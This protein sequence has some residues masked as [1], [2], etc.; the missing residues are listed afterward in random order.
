MAWSDIKE[1]SLT[2]R[3]IQSKTG[4][5]VII[6]LHST[7]LKI[8]EEQRKKLLHYTVQPE[9]VFDLPTANG[10]NKML[11]L[12][13][14]EAGINKKYTWSCARLSFSV[15]LQ[16]ENVDTATVAYLLG[17]TTTKQV[18]RVYK[19]HRPK[20][21]RATIS[22]LPDKNQRQESRS[23]SSVN[24]NTPIN[25]NWELLYGRRQ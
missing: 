25:S 17:H 22:K 9:L 15:L 1:N 7:A 20:D 3:M 5:P 4:Q 16:D 24:L 21:Q 10:A 14:K 23:V 2:T 11:G 18:E 8:I 6:T 12:W 19:R 13:A